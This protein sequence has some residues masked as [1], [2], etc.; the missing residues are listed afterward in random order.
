[1]V[2]QVLLTGGTGFIGSRL[3]DLLLHQGHQVTL[4]S[5]RPDF[6][7]QRWNG[8]IS[9][10]RH[11]DEIQHIKPVDWVINL[12][13]EPIANGRWTEKRKNLI[14]DSRIQITRNLVSQLA[15]QPRSPEAFVSGSAIGYYG[16]QPEDLCTEEHP[17]GVGFSA[18]LC[19]DWEKAAQGLA[20]KGTRTCVLRTGLVLDSNGGALKKML[21][22]FRLGLGGRISSGKQWMSWIHR[23]DL[24][25]LIMFLLEN[26]RCTGPFNGTA[27]EP[28]TNE[29]FCKVLADQLHRPTLLPLPA[30]A[31]RLAMGESSELLLNSQRVI[32]Q[33]AL[34]LGFQFKYE[35]LD[36]CLQKCLSKPR[37]KIA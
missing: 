20:V 29:L 4:F 31:L 9:A 21:P 13:G 10:I 28:V 32:P 14:Q 30:A 17:V 26:E 6:V 34:D 12:A 23:D 3:C 33:K 19:R 1:M 5:R 8:R 35:A 25:R 27:P 16:N 36:A 22:S 11:L 15:R 24:C 18:D 37:K 2:K 7:K